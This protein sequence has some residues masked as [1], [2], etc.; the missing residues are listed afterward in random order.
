M[1]SIEYVDRVEAAKILKVTRECM[2]KWQKNNKGPV[3][4]KRSK[5]YYY[6]LLDLYKFAS[7]YKRHARMRKGD[8]AITELGTVLPR[9]TIRA[10]H[11]NVL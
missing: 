10:H 5:F 9:E 11:G 4:F 6:P 8:V 7:T 2:I 1:N 3:Y